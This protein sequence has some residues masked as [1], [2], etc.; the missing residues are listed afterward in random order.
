M[1]LDERAKVDPHTVAEAA[2][3]AEK[4]VREAAA[5]EAAQKPK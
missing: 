4:A 3:L 1:G 5:R 2:R